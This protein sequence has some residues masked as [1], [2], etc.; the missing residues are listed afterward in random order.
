[1]IAY[2]YLIKYC[3]MLGATVAESDIQITNAT[4]QDKS[5][6][7]AVDYAKAHLKPHR[8]IESVTFERMIL[9]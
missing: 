1:M 8:M 2:K 5:F 9:L 4:A 6:E 3:D 7:L